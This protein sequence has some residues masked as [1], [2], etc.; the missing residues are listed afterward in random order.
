MKRDI[1]DR[2]YSLVYRRFRDEQPE[3][4]LTE[5][6]MDGIWFT[7]YGE[8]RNKSEK[9]VEEWCKTVPLSKKNS[10]TPMRNGY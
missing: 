3:R 2:L 9:E 4:E 5:N 10:H 7:I 8:L 6:D 1:A